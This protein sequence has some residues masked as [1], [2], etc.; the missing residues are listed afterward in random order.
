MIA[1]IKK[2]NFAVIELTRTEVL[3]LLIGQTIEEEDRRRE[4]DGEPTRFH[5]YCSDPAS[6]TEVLDQL[7]H[8][9]KVHEKK[10][11]DCCSFEG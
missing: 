7:E 11:K 6:Y 8:M 5:I 9:G 4:E 3:N 2:I 10:K 1:N